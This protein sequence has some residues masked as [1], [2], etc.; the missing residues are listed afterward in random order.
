MSG[1]ILAADGGLSLTGTNVTYVVV[2]AVIALVALGVAA[3]LVKAVLA[4]DRG[5]PTMQEIAGAVQEGA[6][7]Y[8][9]R[10]LRTVAVFVRLAVVV[11]FFLPVH[12]ADR[13]RDSPSRSAGRS[14]SGRRRASA[15]HR[16]CGDGDGHPGQPAGGR[17][18]RRREGGRSGRCGSPSAPA[19]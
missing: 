11:L 4:T 2:A 15:R 10:Q 17:R 6:A 12:G 7:A 14:S 5:T 18:R 19:A 13:Q 16:R 9:F 8:V 3:A 1:T